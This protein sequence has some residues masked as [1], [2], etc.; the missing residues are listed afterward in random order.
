M[1]NIGERL[2][3]D[4]LRY[5]KGCDFVDFNVYTTTVQGEIDV[6]AINQAKRHAYICAVVTHLTTGI[7]YVKNARPD[8]ADRL[9]KKFLKDIAYG[10]KAFPDY[11]IDYMLW[12]PVV[13]RSNGNPEYNQFAH[14]KRMETEVLEK[15]GIKVSMVINQEFV[16]AFQELRE[17]A[18]Q[19]SKDLKSPVM[20]LLQIE[21]WAQKNS[22]R[23]KKVQS[24][25]TDE[26]TDT[27][28]KSLPIILIPTDP[29]EFKRE[30]LR[31]RKAEIITRYIDGREESKIWNAQ[32]FGETSNVKGNLRSRP[33]FRQGNWQSRGIQDVT[34]R[35]L[36]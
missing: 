34:V 18:R 24:K 19:E 31:T 32:D 17:Y 29:R 11:T 16:D 2:V 10:A 9:I 35:I 6:V 30:L 13:R 22:N 12:S 20:R 26:A 25:I 5:I 3:G 15:T 1:E 8:T 23:I 4:Y 7:Q 33:E 14:L 21:E 36:E 28:A 27:A